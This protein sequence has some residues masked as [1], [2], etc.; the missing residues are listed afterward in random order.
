VVAD[1]SGTVGTG[2]GCTSGQVLCS[3]TI[4]TSGNSVAYKYCCPAGTTTCSYT[5]ASGSS[6]GTLPN[7]DCKNAAGTSLG[8]GAAEIDI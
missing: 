1:G 6:R 2:G 7:V 4:T 5:A 3:F 8:S